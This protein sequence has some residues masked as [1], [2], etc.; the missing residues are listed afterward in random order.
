VVEGD[1]VTLV[2]GNQLIGD[3]RLESGQSLLPPDRETRQTML[4]EALQRTGGGDRAR[5]ES[6]A[7]ARETV[8]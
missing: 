7:A 8:R 5:R 1:L 6:D 3:G 2:P 4:R